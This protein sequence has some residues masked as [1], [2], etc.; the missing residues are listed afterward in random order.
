MSSPGAPRG[1]PVDLLAELV[2]R[3]EQRHLAATPAERSAQDGEIAELAAQSASALYDEPRTDPAPLPKRVSTAMALA[4]LSAPHFVATIP[5]PVREGAVVTEPARRPPEVAPIVTNEVL[6]RALGLTAWEVDELREEVDRRAGKA[7][8]LLRTVNWLWSYFGESRVPPRELQLAGGAAPP[9][10]LA[11]VLLPGNDDARPDIV[12]RGGHV[13]LLTELSPDERPAALYLPWLSP[14]PAVGPTSFR[15]RSVDSSLRHRIARGV[16]GDEDEIAELLEGMVALVPRSDAARW[17]QTD[18]WRTHG[19]AA[20]T[21]LGLPYSV[22]DW[23]VRPLAPDAADWRIWLRGGPEGLRLKGTAEKIFDAL[24]LPRIAAMTRL[25]Y[26]ATLATVD[27]DGGDPGAF[28]RPDDVDLLDVPR[29]V[30]AVLAPLLAWPGRSSTHRLVAT[31]LGVEVEAVAAMLGQLQRDWQ[32]H[33]ATSWWGPP[34]TRAPSIQT[35]LLEH[36]LALQVSLRTL[37]RRP[38]DPRAPHADLVLLFVGHYLREARL[39]RLWLRSLSDV[40]EGHDGRLPPPEDIA[41]TWFWR[42]WRRVLDEVDQ[43]PTGG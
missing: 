24:A 8:K 34:G 22:G 29:H 7:L 37:I 10:A 14:D 23:L 42:A 16:G 21:D 5:A 2:R 17:L 35:L 4:V 11:R 31:E 39:E 25:L 9:R 40:S 19:Y 38:A 1:A 6:E 13:Y 41:G 28:F 20:I 32:A 30:R 26:A 33:A 43:E 15:S 12:R 3:L 27:R 18:Q 36:V